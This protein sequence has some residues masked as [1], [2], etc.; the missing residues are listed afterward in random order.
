MK[1]GLLSLTSITSI[2]E[3]SER[4]AASVQNNKAARLWLVVGAV[5]GSV[6]GWVVQ[7]IKIP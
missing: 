2:K 3:L 5:N 6:V 1:A 4:P 7:V